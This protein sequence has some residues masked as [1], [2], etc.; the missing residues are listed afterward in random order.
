MQKKLL[1]ISG[2]LVVTELFNIAVNDFD[3]KKSACY[4]RMLVV[5]EI[6]VCGI[7]CTIVELLKVKPKKLQSPNKSLWLCHSRE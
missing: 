1:V 5:T 6:V 7:Q 4:S 2:V 3:A